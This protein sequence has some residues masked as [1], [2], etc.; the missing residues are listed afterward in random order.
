MTDFSKSEKI[1]IQDPKM[2]KFENLTENAYISDANKIL[3]MRKFHR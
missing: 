1:E 2:E 3:A